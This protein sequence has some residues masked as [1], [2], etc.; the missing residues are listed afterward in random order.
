MV[1]IPARSVVEALA[2]DIE[3]GRIDP[4]EQIQ[5]AMRDWDPDAVL[6]LVLAC[7]AAGRNVPTS[8]AAELIPHLSNPLILPL[9]VGG[10]EGD[11]ASMLLDLVESNRMGSNLDSVSLFL[12]HHLAEGGPPARLLSLVRAVGRKPLGVEAS[13]LVALLAR[14]LGDPNVLAVVEPWAGMADTPD[15]PRIE[16]LVLDLLNGPVLENL[17]EGTRREIASGFTFKRETPKVGRNDPCPCGSGKKYKKCC[18]N[19]VQ[20]PA[21]AKISSEGRTDALRTASPTISSAQVRSLAVSDLPRLDPE[22]M[23]TGAVIALFKVASLRHQWKTAEAAL[24]ALADRT[25]LPGGCSVDEYRA[26]LIHEAMEV[27]AEDV[28]TGQIS[29]LK[30]QSVLSETDRL[31]LALIRG[32]VDLETLE[33][34]VRKALAEPDGGE[35][36]E[37]AFTLLEHRPALGILFARAALRP[38]RALDSHTLLEVVEEARDRLGLPPSDPG[39]GAWERTIDVDLRRGREDLKKQDRDDERKDVIERAERTRDELERASRRIAQL[40]RQ[41]A[42]H[43]KPRTVVVE[44]PNVASVSSETSDELRAKVRELKGLIAERNEDR[45]RLR[46]ELADLAGQLERQREAAKPPEVDLSGV[47]HAEARSGIEPPRDVL[48]PEIEKRAADALR[49]LPRNV[50]RDALSLVAG[51]A[52][53][54][55]ASWKKTKKLEVASSPILS[56]RVGLHYRLLFAAADGMLCAKEIIHRRDLDKILRRYS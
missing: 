51:L 52:A 19:T 14:R 28:A 30:D 40:E 20:S 54:D 6:A 3:A 1:A 34:S 42:E 45:K 33:S 12:A 16:A 38:D 44:V 2:K 4:T 26:E 39:W 46:Q 9:V 49:V 35:L 55:D 41:L 53:G 21:R 29:A 22:R 5:S 25:D 17:P 37:L 43:A 31:A 18:G 50:V 48:I 11:R 7:R 13:I 27:G 36:I 23:S 24:D 8:A 47:H 10:C 15:A 56:A 32:E